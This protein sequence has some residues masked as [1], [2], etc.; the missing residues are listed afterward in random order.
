[1]EKIRLKSAIAKLNGGDTVR[2]I[3][4]FLKK[5]A[6]LSHMDLNSKYH[7]LI[8]LVGYARDGQAINIAA[9]HA[10]SVST[11]CVEDPAAQLVLKHFLPNF[12]ISSQQSRVTAGSC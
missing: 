8:A 3:W 7:H 12:T 2:I 10:L 1:M 4:R 6:I 5:K 9:P 11:F